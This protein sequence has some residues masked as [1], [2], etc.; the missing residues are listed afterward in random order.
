MHTRYDPNED[1]TFE[2]KS[3]SVPEFK[4]ALKDPESIVTAMRLC[5]VGPSEFSHLTSLTMHVLRE[6]GETQIICIDNLTDEDLRTIAGHIE[7]RLL[8]RT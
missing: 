5:D 3:D 1:N 7:L 4:S 6:G 2:E 8:G